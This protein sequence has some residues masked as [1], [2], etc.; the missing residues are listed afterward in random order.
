MGFSTFDEQFSFMNL[1]GDARAFTAE[2]CTLFVQDI[3]GVE[4]PQP[5]QL[6]PSQQYAL[7]MILKGSSVLVLGTVLT[8][9]S[10]LLW[11]ATACLRQQNKR[12]V[13][14][15]ALQPHTAYLPEAFVALHA[16]TGISLSDTEQDIQAKSQDSQL[17]R[18][19][20][21][22]DVIFIDNMHCLT[23]AYWNKL[24]LAYQVFSKSTGI[25]FVGALDVGLLYSPTTTTTTNTSSHLL[26]QDPSF[27]AMF[28]SKHVLL[29][30]R[31]P[32]SILPEFQ[33]TVSDIRRGAPNIVRYASAW[34]NNPKDDH[35]S[36]TKLSNK[37]AE[38]QQLNETAQS[39][40]SGRELEYK[41]IYGYSN[42]KTGDQYRC[43]PNILSPDTIP[44]LPDQP[45]TYIQARQFLS[46][47]LETTNAL[48]RDQCF[49]HL[50]EYAAAPETLH[51]KVGMWVVLTQTIWVSEGDGVYLYRGARGQV[52]AFTDLR[53]DFPVRYPIVRFQEQPDLPA[54]NIAIV[55]RF[56]RMP[57]DVTEQHSNMLFG[58]MA[59]LPL[60]PAWALN[61]HTISGM[62]LRQ[63]TL[64]SNDVF[65][66]GQFYAVV[67]RTTG[68]GDIHL[69]YMDP[70]NITC[71]TQ[72]VKWSQEHEPEAYRKLLAW[73]NE[74]PA[75]HKY[76]SLP[77]IT[78]PAYTEQDTYATIM[79]SQDSRM[80][81]PLTPNSH[82]KPT[83]SSKKRTASKYLEMAADDDRD[84]GDDLEEEEES[85]L[86]EEEHESD[87]EFIDDN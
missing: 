83:Q 27:Q 68:W 7:D 46:T 85:V 64:N 59:Q 5:F 21:T 66:T 52:V 35:A 1:G 17:C 63:V 60:M 22:V 19:W 80:S 86:E 37:V 23:S 30:D 76:A 74:R 50:K 87:R 55:E 77:T 11:H 15:S 58:W 13:M 29:I 69:L 26:I 56:V 38:V 70:H 12:V 47:V 57:L 41:T 42:D 8:G 14:A 79:E 40:L 75:S 82:T 6:T 34:L 78:A 24:M 3:A 4:E 10:T 49:R 73:L 25:Q 44:D 72:A 9:K 81:Q 84:E 16:V 36:F 43:T 65:Q 53:P 62:L 39:K 20:R 2:E 61:I 33:E 28:A 32:C 18:F 71:V 54:W 45:L 48:Q 67:G 31:V 51:I